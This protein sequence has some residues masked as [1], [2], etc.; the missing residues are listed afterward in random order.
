MTNIAFFDAHSYD[1]ESFNTWNQDFGFRIHYY[2][3]HLSPD[4]VELTKGKEVVCVFVNDEVSA[5]V[6]ERL[7]ENGVR[8]VALRCAGFNNVDLKAAAGKLCVVRVP[9]YSPHAVAEYAVTLML[10]LN[11]KVYRSTQRTREGN[12]RLSGLL[13]FDMYGKTVGIIGMGRIAKEL[14]K[15]LK[16]FGMNV[17]AYDKYPDMEF[18]KE[19]GVSMTDLP[20]LY[21]QSDIISLHCPLTQE[22]LH[23]IDQDAIALMK[24]GVMIINTGRGKLIRTED[25][26]QGLR[27]HKVGSAGLDVYEE[28]AKFFYEDH[29]DRMINDDHLALLLMMPNVIVTSHQAFFTRE[30]LHNIATTTLQNIKDFVDGKRLV[31]EVRT[32]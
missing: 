29:S 22:T 12:F 10:A 11:R 31:N 2:R 20:D 16:G 28:E 21:A 19:H 6:I 14:I 9:A 30:A 17:V 23:M 24:P 1:R 32:L 4:T 8:L 5:S 26:I 18:A 7:V 3:E 25:L 15:I 27:E 13:G